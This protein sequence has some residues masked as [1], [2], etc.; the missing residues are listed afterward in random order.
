M[1][2]ERKCMSH[3]LAPP[4]TPTYHPKITSY[5]SSMCWMRL[6]PTRHDIPTG[7]DFVVEVRVMER[8]TQ[9]GG[10]QTTVGRQENWKKQTSTDRRHGPDAKA[11]ETITAQRNVVWVASARWQPREFLEAARQ[12]RRIV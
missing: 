10:E 3:T 12:E 11:L 2:T 6:P 7:L 9:D 5:D 1:V 8:G 4:Q